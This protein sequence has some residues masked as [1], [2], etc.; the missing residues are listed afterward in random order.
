[1]CALYVQ[2]IITWFRIAPLN[3]SEVLLVP[4][5]LSHISQKTGYLISINDVWGYDTFNFPSIKFLSEHLQL[6][7]WS[8]TDRIKKHVYGLEL[9]QIYHVREWMHGKKVIVSPLVWW[10]IQ[11][12]HVLYLVT[13]K[14]SDSLLMW[15]YF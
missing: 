5:A 12:G 8:F 2:W 7:I 10:Y 13:L 14:L 9:L 1:M 4:G 3:N 15:T 11:G 6:H